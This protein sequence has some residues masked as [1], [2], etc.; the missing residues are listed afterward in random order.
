MVTKQEG[1]ARAGR[2]S[3]RAS[4]SSIQPNTAPTLAAALTMVQ[5]ED[6][7]AALVLAERLPVDLATLLWAIIQKASTR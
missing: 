3:R 1:E 4:P 2:R 7:E 6:G 5:H